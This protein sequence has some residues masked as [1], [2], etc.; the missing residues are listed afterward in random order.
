MKTA[1]LKYIFIICCLFQTMDGFA[2]QD[3]PLEEWQIQNI[4]TGDY[5]KLI[6]HR[7]IRVL[8]PYS[9]TF[10]FLDKGMPRG[11]TYDQM[12]AFE[13]MVNKKLHNPRL[14][15]HVLVIPTPRDNL[16][17]AL[18][19]GKGDIIA[20]NM[21]ITDPRKKKVAF[22]DPY[23]THIN[24]IVVTGPDSPEI[25]TIDDLSGQSIYVRK[26]SSYYESLVKLNKKFIWS[27]KKRVHI[28]QISEYLEDEDLLEML[29]A[30]MISMVVVDSHTAQFWDQIFDKIVLHPQ[31]ILRD[32][33]SIAWAIRKKSPKLMAIINKFIKKNKK[34]T[35]SGNILFE[36]YLKNIHYVRNALVDDKKFQHITK[37]F[38]TYA[39]QYDFDWLLL[40]ALAFQESGINQNKRSPMGAIGIMQVLPSTAR[41][42]NVNI[43]NIYNL[44]A[45]IHAGT[46]YLRYLVDHYFSDPDIDLLNRNLLALAAYN[47]GPNRVSNLR[48]EA[49]SMGLDPN[50]WF[51]NVEVVAAKRI[52]RETVQYVSNIFKYYIAYKLIYDQRAKKPDYLRK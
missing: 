13:K 19:S 25:K 36:R 11:L 38:Q 41:D 17:P 28:I 10:Y 35:R 27:W 9:K 30:G 50:V 23:L 45:N 22:A 20:G 51:Q 42:P 24:E 39:K 1:W 2:V 12:M 32:N 16:I 43:K 15:I 26:T 6:K 40:K 5:D 31:I 33:G 18:L 7:V 21:T 29:N 8:A 4:W 49:Y 47:T 52:G 37:I 3:K 44:N 48:K 34:G 46:K 14:K